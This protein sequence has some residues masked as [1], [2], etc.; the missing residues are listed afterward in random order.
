VAKS[1][2][3]NEPCTTAAEHEADSVAGEDPA[4]PQEVVIEVGFTEENP[5]LS[6]FASTSTAYKSFRLGQRNS[7][8]QTYGKFVL[9]VSFLTK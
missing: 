4:D 2:R 3:K 9:E 1:K 8:I 5:C 6:F 7:V